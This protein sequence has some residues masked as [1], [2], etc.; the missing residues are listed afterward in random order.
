VTTTG[1]SDLRGASRA[2]LA[3]LRDRL[4]PATKG[5][6]VAAVGQELF[7][8]A[9]V[10]DLNPALRRALTDPSRRDD[11]RA[12]LVADLFGDKVSPQAL[13]LVTSAVRAAWS[14]QR[15]LADAL[16]YLGVL[17]QVQV[18]DQEG[19]L[20]ELEDDL[21]RFSR[22]VVGEDALRRALTDSAAPA[23]SRAA[24]AR[25]LLEGKAVPSAVRLVEHAVTAPRGLAFTRALE[26]YGAIAANWRDRLVATV[27]TAIPLRD[28]ERERLASILARQYG[29]EL[30]MNVLVDPEVIGGI[31]IELGDEVIDGTIAGRLSDARRR[32]AGVRG[33][34]T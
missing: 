6:D 26:T 5:A 18:A 29:H 16:E 10:L 14:R 15:D 3:A 13:E 30:H 21:F 28:A 32:L 19:D 7:G 9:S 25:T 23:D 27:H 22:I 33:S 2:S 31:R 24:L 8:V 12:N 20:E 11:D 17:A 34:T 1:T 4:A